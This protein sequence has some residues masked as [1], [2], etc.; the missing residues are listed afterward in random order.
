[1][2]HSGTY[3]LKA[4]LGYMRL[5]LKKTVVQ[6][7]SQGLG[8]IALQVWLLG[9]RKATWREH[10]LSM[11]LPGLVISLTLGGFAVTC[12]ERGSDVLIPSVHPMSLSI[13]PEE[14]L[15]HW[16]PP[17]QLKEDVEKCSPVVACRPLL[18][19]FL[20]TVR[21]SKFCWRLFPSGC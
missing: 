17:F 16:G 6:E 2:S 13:L 10:R 18:F 4:S 15:T 11:S 20:E 19:P 8:Q 7:K 12:G 14:P 3:E 9:I 21:G 5:C 1:M